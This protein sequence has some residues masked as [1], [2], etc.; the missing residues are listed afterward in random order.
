MEYQISTRADGSRHPY[1][2]RLENALT[3]RASVTLTPET[4]K[5]AGWPAFNIPLKDLIEIV[6]KAAVAKVV[7]R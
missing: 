1:S 6:E 3:E 4:T 5:S 7:P 2:Y